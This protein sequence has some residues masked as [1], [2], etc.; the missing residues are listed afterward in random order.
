MNRKEELQYYWV[1]KFSDNHIIE[2]FKE[3]GSENLF[4]Q[5]EEYKSDLVEFSVVSND[6][7][8]EYKVDLVKQVITGPSISES[9]SGKDAKLVY[10][11]RNKVR[12]EVGT[13]KIL[14][15]KVTHNIGLET[16]DDKKVIEVTPSLFMSK[17]KIE[18]VLP[19]TK[20]RKTES[21]SNIT[22]KVGDFKDGM[23]SK[24]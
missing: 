20:L 22:N 5:I 21:R 3:D 18:L 1:A 19:E 7:S 15:T 10:F 16:S 4:K 24:L 9:V 12:G 13:G 6:K 2:Q 14:S 11:R 8:E 17:K 23:V